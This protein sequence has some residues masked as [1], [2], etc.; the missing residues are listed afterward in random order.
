MTFSSQLFTEGQARTLIPQNA[1]VVRVAHHWWGY[2]FVYGVAV[3]ALVCV[4]L[5]FW[6]GYW[7]KLPDLPVW[8][9]AFFGG[10]LLLLA[11]LFIGNLTAASQPSSWLL[12]VTPDRLWV[13]FRSYHH[14]RW[15]HEDKTVLR[16]D[17]LDIEK[18]IPRE[19][20]IVKHEQRVRVRTGA[21]VG[22]GVT[23]RS[24]TDGEMGAPPQYLPQRGQVGNVHY[25]QRSHGEWLRRLDVHLK[26]RLTDEQVS[27][28]TSEN[29]RLFKGHFISSRRDHKP[30]LV[31]GDGK[32]LFIDMRGIHP[33]MKTSLTLFPS[34]YTIEPKQRLGSMTEGAV[35]EVRTGV[36]DLQAAEIAELAQTGRAIDAIKLLRELTGLGLKESKEAIEAGHWKGTS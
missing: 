10:I 21:G 19:G 22:Y 2:P 35:A 7:P 28:V 32:T 8:I 6:R 25:E 17:R 33:S 4:T 34:V 27:A 15:P 14:W 24:E 26:E 9:C 18:L 13:N 11:R 3:L 29:N 36:S 20:Y 30:L 31:G 12:A 16:I 1:L 5:P 23:H